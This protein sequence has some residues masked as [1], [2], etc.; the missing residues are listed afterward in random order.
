MEEKNILTTENS[1]T[2]EEEQIVTFDQKTADLYRDLSSQNKYAQQ[3]ILA[4][5]LAGVGYGTEVISAYNL[6]KN[7][8]DPRKLVEEADYRQRVER[9]LQL[10]ERHE[11]KGLKSGK[12]KYGETVKQTKLALSQVNTTYERI[13]AENVGL[14]KQYGIDV[15]RIYG[16]GDKE[17]EGVYKNVI[18]TIKNNPQLS[19]QQAMRAESERMVV[20]KI[21]NE[22]KQDNKIGPFGK[23]REINKR[24]TAFNLNEKGKSFNQDANV[25]KIIQ[26]EKQ[27]RGQILEEGAQSVAF[28]LGVELKPKEEVKKAPSLPTE[29]VKIP[30]VSLPK[31]TIP[32]ISLP[33][34]PSMGKF[35]GGVGKI[36]K[37]GG[38]LVKSGISSLFSKAVGFVGKQAL[39]KLGLGAATGGIATIA[40][41]GLDII[42][43]LTG[44]DLEGFIIK[45]ALLAVLAPVGL[46]VFFIFFMSSSSSKLFPL[47]AENALIV[48]IENS[49][50]NN[51]SWN[52]FEKEYL[53]TSNRDDKSWEEFETKYL[54]TESE[55]LGLN[56]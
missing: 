19:L 5:A 23:N 52:D 2:Q 50:N 42:K 13:R 56:K 6:L 15:R 54:L 20:K 32:K 26:Y 37:L 48:K 55:Y 51:I 4:L 46:I 47:G 33:K 35:L 38:S 39:V 14:S 11:K 53:V 30:S 34:I 25:Q 49:Q 24:I 21:V 1:E 16:L 28:T 43:A 29:K 8:L 12:S 10:I 27:R 45:A 36:S 7:P 3:F 22:V 41:F 18:E 17:L 40:S 44:I 9:A 31:L